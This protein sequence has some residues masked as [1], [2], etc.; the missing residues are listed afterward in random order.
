MALDRGTPALVVAGHGMFAW[1]ADLTVAR[2]LAEC[3]D[4]LLGYAIAARWHHRPWSARTRLRLHIVAM[5]TPGHSGYQVGAALGR[6]GFATVYLAPG[7]SPLA[8][9]LAVKIDN[10]ALLGERDRAL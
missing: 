10:R 8:G 4:W 6:G 7:S 3:V 1:G 5:E 9:K 2:H